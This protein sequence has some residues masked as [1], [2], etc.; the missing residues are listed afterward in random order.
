[1][2]DPGRPVIPISIGCHSFP[3]AIY[4]FSTSVNIRPKVIYDKIIGDPLLYTDMRLQLAD[5]SICY[6]E[7]I[8]EEAIIIVGQSY[9]PVDFVIMETGVDENAL[10]ILG[11]PFLCTTKAIVYAEHAKIVLSI[12]DKKER[13]SF[14]NRIMKTPVALK[15]FPQQVEQQKAIVPKKKNN[16]RWRRNKTRHEGTAQLVTTLNI[17]NDHMLH[18]PFPIKSGDLGVQIIDCTIKDITFPNTIC[19]I[20]SGC[21]IMSK[22]VYDNLFFDLPLCP[23]YIQL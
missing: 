7:G 9:I 4:D 21:N 1:M 14:K 22:K 23:T 10:I 19:D 18:Q 6:P 20:G 2:G 12:N 17:E 11:R 3:E 5:Q 15:Q 13:F 8:L 16:R